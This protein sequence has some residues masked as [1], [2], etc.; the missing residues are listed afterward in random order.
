M[1]STSLG[2][3]A[4]VFAAGI[5]IGNIITTLLLDKQMIWHIHFRKPFIA[6]FASLIFQLQLCMVL[7]WF[8]LAKMARHI[9]HDDSEPQTHR[10]LF[11]LI[12]TFATMLCVLLFTPH[13]QA[14]VLA[15][16]FMILV[17]WVSG[18]RTPHSLE[19]YT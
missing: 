4:L 17:L 18:Q 9:H 15:S 2:A 13:N 10:T 5:M 1:L 6:I 8:R 11:F 7:G 14:A 16:L 12:A 3:L 19:S